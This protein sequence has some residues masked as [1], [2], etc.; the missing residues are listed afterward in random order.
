[1]LFVSLLCA[2]LILLFS[3]NSKDPI[4]IQLEQTD[5]PVAKIKRHLN[6]KLSYEDL[7]YLTSL[8]AYVDFVQHI[9]KNFYTR[10]DMLMTGL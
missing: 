5:Q 6:Q 7:K 8:T 10:L 3:A 1:V 2:L 4:T 9:S